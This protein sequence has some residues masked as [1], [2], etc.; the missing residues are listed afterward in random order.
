[1]DKGAFDRIEGLV[2]QAVGRMKKL[3]QEN[4]SLKETIRELR[5]E[6]EELEKEQR[7]QSE[8]ISRFR[9]DRKQ[10]R[11][12]VEKLIRSVAVLDESE[13]EFPS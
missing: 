1:M 5:D 8:T 11:T 13:Q 6:L 7:G 2:S 4:V 9:K 10:I 12:R 3:H